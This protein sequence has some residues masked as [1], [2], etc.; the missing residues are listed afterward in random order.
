MVEILNTKEDE[1]ENIEN[2]SEEVLNVQD[3]ITSEGTTEPIAEENEES[4][5]EENE[6]TIDDE[7]LLEDLLVESYSDELLTALESNDTNVDEESIEENIETEEL[8]EVAE[9]ITS[10][11]EEASDDT[12]NPIGKFFD[13][14]IP[15]FSAVNNTFSKIKKSIVSN[16]SPIFK[17]FTFEEATIATSKPQMENSFEDVEKP[18]SDIEQALDGFISTPAIPDLDV[19]AEPV[20]IVQTPVI[21][22]DIAVSPAPSDFTTI[23]SNDI[24]FDNPIVNVVTP[25]ADSNFDL[26]SPEEYTFS[27]RLVDKLVADADLIEDTQKQTEPVVDYN[28]IT[29][30]DIEKLNKDDYND[31]TFS[32]ESYFGIDKVELEKEETDTTEDVEEINEVDEE[33][34]SESSLSSEDFVNKFLEVNTTSPLSSSEIE[35]EIIEEEPVIENIEDEIVIEN[36]EKETKNKKAETSPEIDELLKAKDLEIANLSKLV[37]SFSETISTL[38]NRLASLEE[39][40]VTD[41]PEIIDDQQIEEISEEES[42]EEIEND[43][44]LVENLLSEAFLSKDLNDSLKEE[45]LSEV[46]SYET[47]NDEEASLDDILLE[48]ALLEDLSDEE[49]E[50]FLES[51]TPTSTPTSKKNEV[52]P[53]EATSDFLKIIDSL[54]KAITELEQ[55]PDIK[56]EVHKE[57]SEPVKEKVVELPTELTSTTVTEEKAIN[58]LINKDDIFSISILNESYEIVADFDGISVLSEN[59]HISTPKNN[60]FVKVGNKYIEIHKAEEQFTLYTNFEDIE[61]ANAINN[62]AF[63]KKN[64]KIELNIK[65]AFKLVSVHNKIELSMLNKAIADLSSTTTSQSNSESLTEENSICDNRT[66]LISEETQKVYLPYTIEEVMRKLKNSEVYQ[67]MQE[68]VDNEYTVPLST[69]KMPIIS[70]FKEAY[71]FMRVKEKSSVYAAVDLALELMFNSN[72]NPAVIRA[73]KDLKELNIYLDCLYENEIE[74]FDCFKIVYKVLP[75]IQ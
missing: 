10:I 3:E 49:L 21:E 30:E 41:E 64:N 31:E 45:L 12:H 56:Q 36:V 11:P 35:E 6:I 65:Q 13:S 42:I 40:T 9:T 75:K 44:E 34:P 57:T 25:V 60:F 20:A 73:A 46:L 68:V 4:E 18:L 33:V 29:S 5:N 19:Q 71:R 26:E 62:I 53:E 39:K 24:A 66:L 37:E 51:N 58:I 59:I 54:A 55:T 28:N 14:S 7:E 72:L 23:E 38:S 48:E 2:D 50:N 22:T 15:S 17:K 63:A 16:I 67:T 61:F 69:F 32:I 43:P 27:N 8:S 74:K 70:R 1:I 52:K 47:S